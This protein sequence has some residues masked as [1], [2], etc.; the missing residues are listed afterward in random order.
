MKSVA[1]RQNTSQTF[2]AGARDGHIFLWDARSSSSEPLE[3]LRNVGF[4]HSF[5]NSSNLNSKLKKIKLIGTQLL[6]EE[7]FESTPTPSSRGFTAQYNV[8]YIYERRSHAL[9][10]RICRW[11]VEIMGHEKVVLSKASM[12]GTICSCTISRHINLEQQ[13][14]QQVREIRPSS[15]NRRVGITSMAW[16]LQT[17]LLVSYY[18]TGKIRLFDLSASP[19]NALISVFSVTRTI[20]STSKFLLSDER[21]VVSGSCGRGIYGI[22][23]E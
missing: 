22:F 5:V 12:S 19:S 23:A 10:F 18:R 14:Q 3:R 20:L 6:S 4:T 17:R 13:Q 8:C 11:Y 16:T 1:L 7:T 2:A 9:E 15:K 21:F